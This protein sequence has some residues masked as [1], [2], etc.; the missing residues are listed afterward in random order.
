[1]LNPSSS[2]LSHLFSQHPF[3]KEQNIRIHK[4]ISLRRVRDDDADRHALWHAY[5]KRSLKGAIN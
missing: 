3:G 2:F 1:M 4:W 5:S